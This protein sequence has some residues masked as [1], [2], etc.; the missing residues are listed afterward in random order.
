MKAH[1]SRFWNLVLDKFKRLNAP[2]AVPT[3]ADGDGKL[4]KPSSDRQVMAVV[5]GWAVFSL[6]KAAS[7]AHAPKRQ[8]EMVPLIK[9]LVVPKNRRDQMSLSDPAVLCTVD[10]VKYRTALILKR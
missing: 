7:K 2:K 3:A 1:L 4:S 10:E 8:K 6:L 5:G 9:A